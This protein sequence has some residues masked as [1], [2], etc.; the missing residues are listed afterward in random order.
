MEEKIITFEAEKVKLSSGF[1]KDFVVCTA[2]LMSDGVNRNDSEFTL[3][4][5][6]KS[7]PGFLDKPVLANIWYKRKGGEKEAY[8]GSHDWEV[9]KDENGEEYISYR[10]GERP[11]GVIPG[12][13]SVSI[14][15][16]KGRNFVV[17]KLYLWKQYNYELLKI[18]AKDKKKKVSVE[19]RYTDTEKYTYEGR[20]ITKVNAFDFLGVT[21]LGHKKTL[22][23]EP[24]EIEEGI[25]G[26]HLELDKDQLSEYVMTYEKALSKALMP[27]ETKNYNSLAK[28]FEVNASY[29]IADKREI[30]LS[31]LI[32]AKGEDVVLISISS[33]ESSNEIEGRYFLKGEVYSFR[34]IIN[35][36]GSC[37]IYQEE[38]LEDKEIGAFI[39]YLK[40]N[41]TEKSLDIKEVNLVDAQKYDIGQLIY[42]IFT[43]HN[44]KDIVDYIFI[45][46]DEDWEANPVKGLRKPVAILDENKITYSK[47]S[48]RGLSKEE[49][50]GLYQRIDT[51][52]C[53]QLVT[54]MVKS[55]MAEKYEMGE[56]SKVENEDGKVVSEEAEVINN[57]EE[58]N[59]LEE[60]D[61]NGQEPIENGCDTPVDSEALKENAEDTENK[62]VDEEKPSENPEE[63]EAKSEEEC[64]N[65]DEDEGE[66][67]DEDD[68]EPAEDFEQKYLAA[69]KQ[70]GDYTSQIEALS[71][72]VAK[73]S[74]EKDEMSKELEEVREENA[75]MKED[76]FAK[77]VEEELSLSALDEKN[78]DRIRA[79]AKKHE[80]ADLV[81]V[82]KEIAFVEKQTKTNSYTFGSKITAECS[83][84]AESVFDRLK[85]NL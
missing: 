57:E 46:K 85:R 49:L 54:D 17:A 36:D 79:Q 67:K 33:D 30:L 9:T 10:N 8:V 52:P 16:Y 84:K 12:E 21:I 64:K 73:L 22:L 26:S 58:C 47:E 48:L 1:L 40:I 80:F 38:K 51:I 25:E 69:I 76:A 65:F 62:P 23:G 43:Y 14:Q 66:D 68:E 53:F 19:V 15:K 37:E 2:Y 74:A 18:L 63:S 11:V 31:E 5:L 50:E 77:L 27:N 71:N 59:T 72:E 61:C 29:S 55:I 41:Q 39:K 60:N 78:K 75:K 4:S 32:D 28:E 7:L 13:S 42:K 24:Q 56:T 44:F 34:A 35:I 81:E 6:Q 45:E 70:I 3:E 82:Q 20:T 83:K